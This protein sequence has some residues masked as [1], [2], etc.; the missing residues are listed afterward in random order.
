MVSAA[1][2]ALLYATSPTNLRERLLCWAFWNGGFAAR[3]GSQ[4]AV[5]V[6][7]TVTRCLHHCPSPFPLI[8]S[9]HVFYLPVTF[10]SCWLCGVAG[11]L[12][13][14]AIVY[15]FWTRWYLHCAVVADVVSSPGLRTSAAIWTRG[16][17]L[18]FTLACLRM[19]RCY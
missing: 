7:Y 4:A 1:G 5:F 12:A 11:A 14:A 9:L 6:L 17:L 3:L 18:P 2:R 16:T 10:V 13:P 15:R 8:C 19:T